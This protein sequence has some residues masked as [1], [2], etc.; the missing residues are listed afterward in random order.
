MEMSSIAAFAILHSLILSVEI[1]ART[2]SLG[3]NAAHSR[4]TPGA[5]GC[6][7]DILPIF[8][9]IPKLDCAIKSDGREEL[10]VWRKRNQRNAL[11][12]LWMPF[13]RLPQDSR[14]DGPK[15]DT[16]IIGTIC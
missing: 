14:H 16:A 3:A 7:W 15:L 4:G 11:Y 5:N 2:L 1:E 8:G 12:I 9:G 10:T 6:F 13:Q